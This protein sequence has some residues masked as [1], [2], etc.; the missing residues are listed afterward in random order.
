MKLTASSGLK[1]N[2][3]PDNQLTNNVE[4]KVNNTKPFASTSIPLRVLADLSSKDNQITITSQ[5][6]NKPIPVALSFTPPLTT[7]WKLYTVNHRKFVQ[8]TV[9]GQSDR[10]LTVD[11]VKLNIGD[12]VKVVDCNVSTSQ[13]NKVNLERKWFVSNDVL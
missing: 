13:V 6:T 10:K 5:W 4:I 1:I 9:T 7:S 3:L 2:H 12:D 8:I 11:L